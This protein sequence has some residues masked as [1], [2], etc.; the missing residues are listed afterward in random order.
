MGNDDLPASLREIVE[1]IGRERA[2]YLVGNYPRI[3]DKRNSCRR[4][5]IYVPRNPKPGHPLITV[6]GPADAQRI[7]DAF[8]GEILKPPTCK[9]IYRRFRNRHIIRLV[10]EGVPRRM[11]SEWFGISYRAVNMIVFN[12]A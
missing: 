8:S 6:L 9:R 1:V 10:S 3:P 11:V 2:L 4:V 5:N 12:A 7:I